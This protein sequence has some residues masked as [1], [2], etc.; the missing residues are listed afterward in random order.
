MRYLILAAIV[1]IIALPVNAQKDTTKVDK[2]IIK[3]DNVISQSTKDSINSLKKPRKA[4][5]MSAIVPGL[6]QA[7]NE[8]YWKI[9]IIYSALGL[10]IYFN[11]YNYK[12]YKRYL[13][14]YIAETD[15]LPETVSEFAGQISVDNLEYNKDSFRRNRDISFL[16]LVLVYFFNIIDATVDSH[17]FDFDIGEDLS[18]K[19]LPTVIP[20]YNAQII[21]HF[22]L[23]LYIRF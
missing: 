15:T 6:G 2:I 11:D 23:S 20:T 4:A 7:Y 10:A 21:N 16:A 22:G 14:A 18:L 17:L 1:L 5:L 8:K 19:V 9:P 12:Q 13:N 3:K